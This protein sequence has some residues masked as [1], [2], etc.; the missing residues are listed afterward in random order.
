MYS[1]STN[2]TNQLEVLLENVVQKLRVN[3]GSA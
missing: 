2:A 1:L 3:F